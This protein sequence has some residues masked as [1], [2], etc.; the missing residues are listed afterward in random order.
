[1][2]KSVS[3][4]GTDK[5]FFQKVKM[6]DFTSCASENCYTELQ[7]IVFLGTEETGQSLSVICFSTQQ[8]SSDSLL[9]I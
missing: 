6:I 2:T 4:K 7:G 9:H 8:N 3:P 5:I 1:M